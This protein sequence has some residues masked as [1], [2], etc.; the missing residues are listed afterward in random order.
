[1]KDG[2][3]PIPVFQKN[4]L[5]NANAAAAAGSNFLDQT[6]HDLL[7]KLIKTDGKLIRAVL[8][9]NGFLQTES[10]HDWNILWTCQSLKVS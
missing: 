7:Y 5:L 1:M 10:N 4:A 9:N 8:E 3:L 6:H 2:P